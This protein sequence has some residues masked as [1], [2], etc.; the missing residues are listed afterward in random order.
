MIGRFNTD[1]FYEIAT[2]VDI[3]TLKACLAT[4]IKKRGLE[5]AYENGV[6][7]TYARVRVRAK[8]DEESLED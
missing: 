1:M 5:P 4:Y 8:A 7:K 3:D 6:L 2:P